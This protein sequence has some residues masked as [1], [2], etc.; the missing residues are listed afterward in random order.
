MFG[1]VRVT[2]ATCS[3]HFFV[4]T[5][6]ITSKQ[7]Q[8]HSRQCF[9]VG[10][11]RTIAASATLLYNTIIH[12]NINI[13]NSYNHDLPHISV[14]PN[15]IRQVFLNL[16]INAG[17]AMPKGGDLEISTYRSADGGYVCAEIKDTGA[18]I[19]EENITRIFD[20]FF[21]TKP[22]GT[23]LGLAISYGIIENNGGRIEVKSTLG[24]GT[25]F[26]VMLRVSN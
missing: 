21:T 15:Q 12:I 2:V 17:H 23:G 8:S 3:C 5:T 25:I 14:D 1:A 20:P 6:S 4:A 24:E 26:V 7:Q 11:T 22:E 19:P 9:G 16:I 13:K 10:A 18:G